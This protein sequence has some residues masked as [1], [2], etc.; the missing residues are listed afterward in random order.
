[1]GKSIFGFNLFKKIFFDTKGGKHQKQDSE[2]LLWSR[3]LTIAMI[4]AVV[5]SAG[6]LKS[7]RGGWRRAM[8]LRNLLI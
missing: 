6:G 1:M 7:A 2:S 5:G 4:Q 8:Q 3:S